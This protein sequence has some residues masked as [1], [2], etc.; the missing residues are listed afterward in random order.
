MTVIVMKKDDFN[1]TQFNNAKNIAF[2][3]TTFTI[4]KS[5]DLTVTY[6]KSDYLISIKW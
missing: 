2:D 6:N 4:T 1:V 3:S 5:D